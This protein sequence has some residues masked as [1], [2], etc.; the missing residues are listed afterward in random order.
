MLSIIVPASSHSGISGMQIVTY[1]I[2]VVAAAAVIALVTYVF[3][4]S[5][6]MYHKIDR[7]DE[8]VVGRE[9]SRYEPDPPPGLAA[10]AVENRA[11]IASQRSMLIQYGDALTRHGRIL[12]RLL[13]KTDLVIDRADLLVKDTLADDGSSQRDAIDRIEAAVAPFAAEKHN[14]ESPPQVGLD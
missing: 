3:T 8:A 12:E 11:D 4:K 1:V 5:R 2:G 9:K 14:G 6:V 13:T 7:V 10:I